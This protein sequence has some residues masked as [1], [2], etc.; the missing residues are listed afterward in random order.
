MM[1]FFSWIFVSVV[2]G[3]AALVLSKS[4]QNGEYIIEFDDSSIEQSLSKAKFSLIY[5]YSDT[6][7]YCRQFEPDF[8]SLSVLYN[9]VTTDN[10]KNLQIIKTNAKK[11]SRLSELF[12]IR[13]YPTLKLLNFET[14]EIIDYDRTNRDIDT[15][16]DFLAS[17][18]PDAV[19][20]NYNKVKELDES[21]F[22]D[23]IS[24]SSSGVMVV[25]TMSY[26]N[27]W[28]HYDMPGHYF[29]KFA[30]SSESDVQFGIV[31]A[32]K[33]STGELVSKYQI[34]NF[35]SIIYFAN[36]GKFKTYKTRASNHLDTEAL[37]EPEIT[38]F[39]LNLDSQDEIYGTWFN[40]IADL[41]ASYE[42]SVE[43]D[44][45]KQHRAGFNV[46]QNAKKEKEGS[47]DVD[48]E[49]NDLLEHIEL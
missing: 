24:G 5:F 44:G 21:N 46:R 14:K 13:R 28:N 6:C 16:I 30:S 45:F 26:V 36:D 4:I 15:V 48:E 18:V 49:Y 20:G 38:E 42:N 27:G 11:N 25:F 34:S 47:A 7:K 31:D 9:N 41:E 40:S 23:F 8:E 19:P 1:H 43:Y 37:K 32:E 10:G 33:V 3:H 2:L 35:P 12:S 39:L 17:M 29:Q 22:D